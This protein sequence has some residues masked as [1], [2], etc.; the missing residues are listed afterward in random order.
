MSVGRKSFAVFG[1]IC[2]KQRLAGGVCGGHR[3]KAASRRGSRHVS[4]GARAGQ[5]KFAKSRKIY[6]RERG[7]LIA[8]WHGNFSAR[9][10]ARMH[11]FC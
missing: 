9:A 7:E 4:I 5:T 6:F 10:Q 8:I 11:G 2:R 1:D 3:V